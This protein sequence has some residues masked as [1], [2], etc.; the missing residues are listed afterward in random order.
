MR[1]LYKIGMKKWFP[2]LLGCALGM[3]A[4]AADARLA[5][6]E[7]FKVEP[8]SRAVGVETIHRTSSTV[9]SVFL[10]V[11]ASEN[12]YLEDLNALGFDDAYPA[13]FSFSDGSLGTAFIDVDMR[14]GSRLERCVAELAERFEASSSR[15]EKLERL[16]HFL[17]DFLDPVP[18]GKR[19]PWEPSR[20]PALPPEFAAAA[21]LKVGHFPLLTK[22]TQPEVPLEAFLQARQGVCVQRVLLL[23]LLMKKLSLRHRVRAGGVDLAGNGEGGGGHVWIELPDRRHLDPT[24]HLLEKPSTAGAL[25]GWFGIGHSFLFRNQVFPVAVDE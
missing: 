25:D 9:I 7:G 16:V 1:A 13:R 19:F 6:L 22:L 23:S 18:E 21:D 2:I 15:K 20:K 4:A 10:P 17:D 11:P 14:P 3:P 8:R 5:C 24:W 12:G